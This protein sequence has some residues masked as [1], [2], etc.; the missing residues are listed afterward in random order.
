M[1]DT[2]IPTFHY[3]SPTV[4]PEALGTHSD[5][6]KD[7]DLC[8]LAAVGEA[9]SRGARDVAELP[10]PSTIASTPNSSIKEE[11]QEDRR[12]AEESKRRNSCYIQPIQHTLGPAQ[13][14][15]MERAGQ[16]GK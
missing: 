6:A 2:L 13:P 15:L 12:V 16:A 1:E 14:T 3:A 9:I 11:D 4:E 5:Q 7:V 8:V 10:V